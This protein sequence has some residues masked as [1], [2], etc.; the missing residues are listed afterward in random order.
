MVHPDPFDNPQ[1]FPGKGLRVVSLYSGAGG[2]DDGFHRAG[3]EAVFANDC[4]RDAV[5]SY[6][7]NLPGGVA[8]E[9]SVNAPHV[10]TAISRFVGAD[11]VIGGPPCQGFSVAGNMDPDD[12]RSAHVWRFLEVV[13]ELQPT[14]FVMENVKAL[15]RNRRWKGLLDA[16]RMYAR[17]HLGYDVAL[18]VLN[19]ADYR[20]PQARE[21]M[22]LVGIRGIAPTEPPRPPGPAPT[23]RDALASLP[24][25]GS[26]GNDQLCT[27]VI[28]P[29]KNPVLRRSPHAGLLFNGKGRALSLDRPALT[30]PATMGGNRTPI[31]DEGHRSGGREW[32]VDYHATLMSGGGPVDRV[33]SRLRRLTVDEAAALQT[34]RRGWTFTGRQGSR[35][36]QIGNAVPPRLAYAIATH[37]GE[38]MCARFDSA[39]ANPNRVLEYAAY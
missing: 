29:A 27:A 28:T 15:A 4:D 22:F 16:L 33:P 25:A 2:L 18:F 24:P 3:F 8:V 11:V 23:V 9:G 13:A 31:V 30:L 20:V 14:A 39:A 34:F 5:A 26:P 17:D 12:P 38:Q 35:F 32:I 37:L 21:R 6:N 1:H 7:A 19:A 10:R 36:R